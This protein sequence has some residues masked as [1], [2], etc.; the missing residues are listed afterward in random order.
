MKIWNKDSMVQEGNKDMEEGV[1][2][3]GKKYKEGKENIK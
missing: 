3:N 2:N 1:G